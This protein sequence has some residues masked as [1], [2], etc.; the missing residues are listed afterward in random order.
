MSSLAAQVQK[1]TMAIEEFAKLLTFGHEFYVR[2][3]VHGKASPVLLSQR[4]LDNIV[5]AYPKETLDIPGSALPLKPEECLAV[6]RQFRESTSVSRI[7][8]VS[9]LCKHMR[10]GQAKK[11]PAVGNLPPNTLRDHVLYA[12]LVP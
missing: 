3:Y 7:H 4:I 12:S 10:A 1:S 9:E 8:Y 5:S 6:S 11:S 2:N